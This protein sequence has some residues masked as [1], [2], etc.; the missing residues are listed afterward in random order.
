MFDNVS[1]TVRA[2]ATD[3]AWAQWDALGAQVTG[4]RT[5]RSIVDPE[6]L[7]LLSL[8]LREDELRLW[9]LLGWWAA[10]GSH[11]LSVQRIK[12]LVDDYA[13]DASERLG[14]FARLAKSEGSDARW[15][16][17]AS[18]VSGPEVRPSK[19]R[20]GEP[21]VVTPAALLLRLRLGLGVGVK[22]DLLGLLLGL[23]GEAA[24]VRVLAEATAYSKRSVK[25]AADE[26]ADA[27]LIEASR[28]PPTTYRLEPA[29]WIE[30]LDLSEPAPRWRHWYPVFALVTHL[31]AWL[32]KVDDEE[33]GR[34][35]ASSRARSLVEAHRP[36]FERNRISIPEPEDHPGTEYLAAFHETVNTLCGWMREMV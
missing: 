15:G 13:P 14:E 20:A 19:A 8:C 9:D 17:L 21:T 6:A 31:L 16:R 23:E 18:A 24:S 10:R 2:A 26:M 12:N 7:V 3:V 22:A 34:H 1:G 11:L 30:L 25:R 28:Q 4:A 27:R 36:A 35:V 33:V 5:A 29:P 32:E